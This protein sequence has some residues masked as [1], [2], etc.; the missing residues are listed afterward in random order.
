M[1][2]LDAILRSPIR[3]M[4]QAKDAGIRSFLDDLQANILKGHGRHFTGNIFISFEGMGEAAVAA[5]LRDLS[6]YVTSALQQLR[7]ARS[8]A[9]PG[10][11][12]GPVRCLLLGAGAYRALGQLAAMPGDAAFQ[13]GMRARQAMLADP[14]ANAWGEGAWRPGNPA[15]DAMLLLANSSFDAVT[16]DL[17]AAEG[18]LDGT[19]A[20]VLGVERG[21]AQF[22][23][24]RPGGPQEGVEHF[25]YVDGRSQPLFLAEDLER[26]EAAS[27]QEPAP[28]GADRGF[29][30][31]FPPSQ[32]ILADPN[33][34][35]PLAAG[36]YFVFRKLE[37]RVR[38][39]KQQ[40]AALA[41][42]L[43]LTGADAE[44]AGA[45]VVGRFEDGTPVVLS[46][47]ATAAP[48]PNNF[49][50]AND[51]QGMR[52]PFQSH[53]RKTNPRGESTPKLPPEAPEERSHIM[54]RR[55][56]P[57]GDAVRD[58]EAEE[59]QEPEG[60]VGLLFMAYMASIVGQ[61]E[62]TQQAWANNPRFLRGLA[63]G[64]APTGIDPVIGQGGDQ[65][66]RTQDWPVGEGKPMVP[67]AFADFVRMQCGENFF[68]PSRSFL[69]E[70][71][72]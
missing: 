67:F 61:F 44:R 69:R 12:G 19:G 33:A 15:P 60:E 58:F 65:A 30:P 40:E 52:C 9:G 17:E 39:F 43:G 68:A 63:A 16:R 50:Y 57:F 28:I 21:R 49:S 56:I 1:A 59:G 71:G 24:F 14:P 70:V 8:S 32:F 38:A 3:W 66:A 53:I 26:E 41:E 47:D 18:W 45:M 4:D 64:E 11:D 6:G 54:A 42:A 36:S 7:T 48:P 62:F 13:A 25:G 10:F 2:Q 34:R 46:D 20:R 31:A 29:D 55:G 22:R 27:G 51:P 23:Q 5:L 72:L 35:H 37:Q